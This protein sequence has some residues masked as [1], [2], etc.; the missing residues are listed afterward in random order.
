MKKA[1]A[2]ILLTAFAALTVPA[3][4]AGGFEIGVGANYWHSMKDAVSDSFDRDG[5]GWMATS[6]IMFNG[7]GIGL[8]LEESPDN[9]VALEEPVY[10]PAAYVIVGGNIYAALGIGTYYYDGDFI[11]DTWYSFR[12]GLE[13][14]VLLPCMV[15]DLNLNYRVEKWSEMDTKD[16]DSDKI[17]IGAALRLAF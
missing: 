8:E 6:K 10:Y 16:F 2:T 7:W 12:V 13:T 5:L 1:L 4:H 3:V 11:D 15:L 9:F 14:P 17:I